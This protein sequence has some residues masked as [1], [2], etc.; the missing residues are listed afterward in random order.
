MINTLL[1]TITASKYI[2]GIYW[3]STN[4]GNL[5]YAS[6]SETETGLMAIYR[7]IVLLELSIYFGALKYIAQ[8]FYEKCSIALILSQIVCLILKLFNI[9][10]N[11]FHLIKNKCIIHKRAINIKNLLNMDYLQNEVFDNV[12][13]IRK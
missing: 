2:S 6:V 1:G 12:N 13:P 10:G 3:V 5:E 4:Y 8:T 11:F 7:P 9:N